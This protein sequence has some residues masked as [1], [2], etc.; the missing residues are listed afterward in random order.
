MSERATQ[1]LAISVVLLLGVGALL[2]VPADTYAFLGISSQTHAVSVNADKVIDASITTNTAVPTDGGSG[3]FGYGLIFLDADGNVDLS[4]IVVSTTHA[5]V[6]DS[7][8]QTSASDPVFHNHYV[9]LTDNENDNKCPG[10]EVVNIT[11][12]QPGSTS[13]GGS[14]VGMSDVPF[15]FSGTHSL[16]GAD[17]SFAASG[18]VA[19]AVSFTINPVDANGDTSVTDIQAVCINDVSLVD[20]QQRARVCR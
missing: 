19:K 18:H 12:Q 4:N 17:I 14:T 10:L 9:S 6:L 20:T 8:A 16:S 1:F 11:F 2:L 7:E 13:V 3:A 5:G 15:V